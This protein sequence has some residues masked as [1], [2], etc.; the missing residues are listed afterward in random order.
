[1]MI[2]LERGPGVGVGRCTAVASR[3]PSWISLTDAASS[4]MDA[5]RDLSVNLASS[6]TTGSFTLQGCGGGLR[7]SL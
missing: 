2:C 1:M 6:A 3:V 5:S 4:G 7:A